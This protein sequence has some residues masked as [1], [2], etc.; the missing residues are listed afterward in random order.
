VRAEGYSPGTQRVRVRVGPHEDWVDAESLEVAEPPPT[1][2][3]RLAG[4][5]GAL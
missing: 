4:S 2:W 3:E 1:S 5:E